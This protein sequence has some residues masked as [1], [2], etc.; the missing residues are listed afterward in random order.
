MNTLSN[1]VVAGQ[2]Y[3]SQNGR[4]GVSYDWQ[5]LYAAAAVATIDS[6]LAALT[7]ALAE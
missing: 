3:F 1:N 4:K 6:E 7:P 5:S 2:T